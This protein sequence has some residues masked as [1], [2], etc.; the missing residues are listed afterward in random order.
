MAA[1]AICGAEIF[2]LNPFYLDVV[3]LGVTPLLIL[4]P[5]TLFVWLYVACAFFTFHQ[6]NH[7][8]NPGRQLSLQLGTIPK[9]VRGVGIVIDEPVKN[10]VS[11]RVVQS[12][13]KVRL[14]KMGPTETIPLPEDNA[15]ILMKWTG[16]VPSYGD[17]VEFTGSIQPIPGPRNPGQMDFAGY[18]ERVGI[19]SEV[20]V[21]YPKDG[22]ILSHGHGHCWTVLANASRLWMQTK[23]SLDLQD[24]PVIADLIQSLVLGLKEQTPEE[25][26]DWFRHTG[27]AHLFV[28]NGLHI[29]MFALI[30]QFIVKPFGIN[31]R[32]SVFLVIPLLIFYTLVTGFNPGSI[33]ATLMAAVLL[34]GRFFDRQSISINTL[35][36]AAFAILSWDTQQLFM[37]GFQF[38][39]GVV[40]T[41]ILLARR[42]SRLF[43]GLGRP[44]LFLPQTLWSSFQEIRYFC[45]Q[46]GA[47]LFSLS[48]A[49][50]I[51]AMPFTLCYFHL[52][53][54]GAAVANL[55]V[56]P[57]A[58]IVLTQGILAL[59]AGIGSL[60]LT[61]CFN[62][63]NWA[64]AQ[65]LLLVVRFFAQLPGGYLFVGPPF[66]HPA[67]CEITVFD[68]NHGDSIY[69][70]SKSEDWLIDTGSSTAYANTVRPFLQMH[71]ING[72][73]GLIL[74]NGGGSSI[75]GAAS[76]LLDFKPNAVIDS[77]V[78]DQSVPHRAFTHTLEK[79][80][81]GKGIYEAGDFLQI[82]KETNVRFLYPP[83]GL[84][85]RVL[86]DK[87][88]VLQI[89]TNKFRILLMSNT[90]FLAE[91]WLLEHE[92][93]LKSDLLIMGRHPSDLSGTPDFIAAV[94]PQVIIV[95]STGFKLDKENSAAWI[96]NLTVRGIPLFLQDSTGAVRIELYK[97]RYS[98][99]AFLGNQIFI[100]K[101]R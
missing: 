76:A 33:R 49:A 99:E 72:L 16:T 45:C 88:M 13:F 66:L 65:F 42:I 95:A 12:H 77:T 11:H 38:S 31:R 51:G 96:R 26:R 93:D 74:A 25:I 84:H 1:S 40:L 19:Y 6:I 62:N 100:K 73:E 59:L 83:A 35:A 98:V 68:F 67:E 75:G 39:F 50:W 70:K 2:P 89:I 86:D 23:L 57:I 52:I 47:G 48:L 82:S 85:V 29:G 28:V 9:T 94:Q 56:V 21:Q 22:T 34:A 64:A 14:E 10:N 5:V 8:E 55:I 3:L 63:A 78:Q 41:I 61:V 81:Q 44:D 54:P 60:S 43:C 30:A 80:E 36:A 32:R 17:R 20:R 27:T 46:H 90:G 24:A 18:L 97:D 69:L 37:P 4:R 79:M 15:T 58:F 71:G 87:A 91:C 92:R 101:S 53:S 7:W